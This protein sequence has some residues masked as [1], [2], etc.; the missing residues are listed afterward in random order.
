MWK[1]S[2]D[3][4]FFIVVSLVAVFCDVSVA[5][6]S[7][8]TDQITIVCIGDSHFAPGSPLTRYMQ[9]E[10]GDG[11]RIVSAG[12]VGWSS[13]GW[14]NHRSDWTRLTSEADFVFIS[15]NGNDIAQNIPPSQ[16]QTNIQTLIELIPDDI[17]Y[18]HIT[19]P[20]EVV[21][22]LRLTRDG[23]HLTRNGARTYARILINEYFSMVDGC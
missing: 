22:P 5:D 1:Y 2:F 10:L 21:P 9:R 8:R 3:I 11:F 20:N 6:S 16:T 7:C 14:M 19:R 17:D 12:R 23:I 4:F 15:L 18:I 13:R